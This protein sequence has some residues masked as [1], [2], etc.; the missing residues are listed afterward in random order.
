[1]K[2]RPLR[3]AERED[4]AFPL[5]PDMLHVFLMTL[6]SGQMLHRVQRRFIASVRRRKVCR[7]FHGRMMRRGQ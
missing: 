3:M 5:P 1:M 6:A 4:S 7:G 2:C